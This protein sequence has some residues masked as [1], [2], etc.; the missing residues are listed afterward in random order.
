[1]APGSVSSVSSS[2]FPSR[3]TSPSGSCGLPG[4]D[5]PGTTSFCSPR[6]IWK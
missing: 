6:L 5:K 4:A 2:S 3:D 1:M